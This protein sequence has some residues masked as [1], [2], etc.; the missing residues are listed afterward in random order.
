M[1]KGKPATPLEAR[2]LSDHWPEDSPV[3]WHAAH[4]LLAFLQFASPG[5]RRFHYRVY[6]A[7][8]WLVQ[9]AVPIERCLLGCCEPV[10]DSSNVVYNLFTELAASPPQAVW[11]AADL[12]LPQADLLSLMLPLSRRAARAAGPPTRDKVLDVL[13]LAANS[14]P[15]LTAV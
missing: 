7:Y 2:L 12:R 13:A 1:F 10:T 15:H 11:L 3:H 5:R 14:T 9:A 8:S 4:F 6:A